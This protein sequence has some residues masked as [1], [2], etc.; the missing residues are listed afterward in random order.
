MA[1][2]TMPL[3]VVEEIGCPGLPCIT[4]DPT[5]PAG[6]EYLAVCTGYGELLGR[7]IHCPPECGGHPI[8]R[9]CW[10]LSQAKSLA[11]SDS[12]VSDG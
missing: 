7:S 12:R 6:P 8:C 1:T 9:P 2:E 3:E 4:Q 5:E 10:E 11:A